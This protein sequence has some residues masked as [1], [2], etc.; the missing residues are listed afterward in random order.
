[1]HTITQHNRHK[2]CCRH[3]HLPIPT[4]SQLFFL[5]ISLSGLEASVVWQ[6][7][8]V[9]PAARKRVGW[10][11]TERGCRKHKVEERRQSSCLLSPIPPLLLLFFLLLAPVLSLL[12]LLFCWKPLHLNVYEINIFASVCLVSLSCF[13]I[14]LFIFVLD[15]HK[16]CVSGISAVLFLSS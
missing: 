2:L 6:F 8:Q 4:S 5:E 1:M 14:R 3:E 7:N 12:L 11:T 13:Y 15:S 16:Q 10:K 9:P